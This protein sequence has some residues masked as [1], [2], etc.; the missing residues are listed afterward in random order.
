MVTV[1]VVA[2]IVPLALLSAY[3]IAFGPLRDDSLYWWQ[4]LVGPLLIAAAC[5]PWAGPRRAAII[6][7]VGVPTAAL[8]TLALGLALVLVIPG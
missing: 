4:I 5:A 8:A 2:G 7:L 3:D 1:G 6:A